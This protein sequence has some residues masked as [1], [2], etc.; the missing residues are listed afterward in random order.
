MSNG[1]EDGTL[2][3]IVG[4]FIKGP[5]LS[6]RGVARSLFYGCLP[7]LFLPLLIWTFC[8]SQQNFDI[9]KLSIVAF[10]ADGERSSEWRI[11]DEQGVR[12]VIS[13][14]TV[15][16]Q[17]SN[18]LT[19][20]QVRFALGPKW[21]AVNIFKLNAYLSP[22][23]AI[24]G[25]VLAWFFLKR[26]ELKKLQQTTLTT[27]VAQRVYEQSNHT[28]AS[29]GQLEKRA[30]TSLFQ[31]E[32]VSELSHCHAPAFTSALAPVTPFTFAEPQADHKR[33][34]SPF[35]SSA[36]MSVDST[37]MLEQVSPAAIESDIDLS[38]LAHVRRD[39]PNTL[40]TPVTPA[41]ADHVGQANWITPVGDASSHT[42][43]GH[44]HAGTT[45]ENAS[46][47]EIAPQS[48]RHT[49]TGTIKAGKVRNSVDAVKTDRAAKSSAPV[50]STPLPPSVLPLRAAA[51]Q[52]E[53]FPTEVLDGALS[54]AVDVAVPVAAAT[55]PAKDES[56]LNLGDLYRAIDWKSPHKSALNYFEDEAP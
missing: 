26:G 52:A 49:S 33:L 5:Q 21:G 50:T 12:Q 17:R 24:A 45:P 40:V 19:P 13:A 30:T 36:E 22:V 27:Q 55:A 53:L 34:P 2:A 43:R 47:V 9:V 3:K 35:R 6:D 56:K 16:G 42:K 46:S 54:A 28:A 20:E 11:R 39:F 51:Q 15:D 18:L 23:A 7:G 37:K 41:T 4:V 38:P 8:V 14:V 31:T 29:P 1:R 44:R 25:L 10:V 48:N 32:R